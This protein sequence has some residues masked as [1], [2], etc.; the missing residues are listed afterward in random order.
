MDVREALEKASQEME[1]SPVEA[2]PVSTPEPEVVDVAPETV[3]TKTETEKSPLERARDDE[4]KF[5]KASKAKSVTP[6]ESAGVAPE[7]KAAD[8][9]EE[10]APSPPPPPAP[11]VSTL[12][13]PASW[14]P[15]A[16][17]AFSKAPPEVQAEIHRREGEITRTLQET[18]EA[19]KTMETVR[20]TLAPFEG[21][22]RANGMDSIKYAGSVM[23]TA[24][25]LSMG[26]QT[27]R[28]HIVAQLIA[29]YGI[30]VDSVNAVMQGQVPQQ[31]P[32]QQQIDPRAVVR[33]EI[34]A[35]RQQAQQE[36]A[37]SLW[38]DFSSKAPEFLDTVK[39]D[40]VVI[41]N[42]AAR[43]G[44]DITY[45][46]AY[47]KACRLND[48]ISGIISQ[49]QAAQAA[50]A[51]GTVTAATRAAASSPRSRPAAPPGGVQPRDV[52]GALEAA[53]EKIGFGG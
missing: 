44:K 18:A 11:V 40:M 5:A 1:S 30:D 6:K 16:K 38:R 46:Q 7:A 32:A 34:A 23:Q 36:R 53:A 15:A 39:D 37:S 3:E 52:R 48:E 2:E 13:A 42:D 50:R 26:S 31:S 4:G 41:L 10:E 8:G 51:P 17:E 29:S 12:K 43:V 28:A 9:A 47:D 20:Q 25:A 33:E 19:R 27:Q 14:K 22:A 35:L 21:L 24:A 45:Q 49:R